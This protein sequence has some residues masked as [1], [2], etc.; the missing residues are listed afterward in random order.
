MAQSNFVFLK[1]TDDFLFTILH[2]A[3]K[4]YPDDANTTLVKLRIAG[5]YVA[6]HL[7]KLL[8]I[9]PQD[10]QYALL[11]EIA[12][13]TPIDE[14]ILRI[15]HKLRSLGNDAVHKY[16][17]DLNDAEMCLR[18]SFRLAVWYYRLMSNDKDFA[19]PLFKLP[20]DKAS[21]QK[22]EQEIAELKKLLLEANNN[23]AQKEHK[24]QAELDA[25]QAKVIQLEGLLAVL[26]SKEKETLAQNEA[27]ILAL[28]SQLKQKDVELAKLSES[29]R[30]SFH[31]QTIKQANQ[32]PLNLNEQETRYLIDEQ[33]RL[34]GWETDT[35]NLKYSNGTRPQIGRNMAIA[36]W[37][38]GVDE[39]GKKGF[40]DYV[41]FIGLTPVGV[42]EAKRYNQDVADKL[43]EAYRYSRTFDMLA[44]QNE[45]A[46]L[47]ANDEHNQDGILKH[48]S[49]MKTNQYN[50]SGFHIPFCFSANGRGH[51]AAVKTKSGIWYRDVRLD[52]NQPDS[53]NQ[54]F[55]PA[56]L[57][58]KL[59]QQ[60]GKLNSWFKTNPDMSDLGLRYFQE[61]A[62]RA[63]E[64]AVIEG[65][66]SALLA[67]A[68]GTGKTRTAIAIMYRMI[69]SQR[70]K[71]VL[72]LVDRR[73]LG[74]QALNS[75]E[76]TRIQSYTFNEI[77]NIKGLTDRFPEDSTKVHIATVQSLVKRV[78]QGDNFVGVGTYDAIIIDEAHR[79]YIL[80]KEQTEGELAFRDQRDYISAYRRVIDHF[81]A[82]K[83]ALT[84]TPA[85]HTSE[86]FGRPVYTYSY[87]TAVIDGYLNDYEP[88]IK[89][90][91][92]LNTQGVCI[93]EGEQVERL[94]V[95]GDV[96]LDTL[97]DEQNFEVDHFNRQIILPNFTKAI[98]GE[99]TKYLDPTSEQKT[100]I[101]CVNNEH[102][103]T[104]VAELHAAFKG[105]YPDL[106]HDAIMKIT[107]NSD[108][109]ANKV[110][111][112]IVK[113]E[114]EP[115]IP[116]IV[117]T[118]DLLTTG[119]DVPSICNLVFLR[120]VRS[121]I[122]YEQMKGR[123]TRLCP[124]VG[125]TSFRIFDAVDL[126]STLQPVDTM[127]SVVVRPNVSL[128]TLVKEIS[129]EETYQV[130]E[131]NDKSFAENSHEQL[132]SKLQRVIV[133]AEYQQVRSPEVEK[134][135]KSID[136]RLKNV[137]PCGFLELAKTL[138]NEG[139]KVSAQYFEKLPTLVEQVEDLKRTINSLRDRPI[140]SDM[141]DEVIGVETLFGDYNKAEDFL[142]AF[143]RLVNDNKNKLTALNAV[144]NRPRDLTR[145]GLVELQ[146]WFDAKHFD[147]SAL[148]VA[149]YKT[150]TQEIAAKLV[151]HIRRA[152]MKNPV[153]QPFDARVDHALAKIK[154][155]ND[156]NSVQIQ[157]LDRLAS[158]I[159]EKVVLDDDVYK[160]GNYARYGG[161]RKLQEALNDE[162]DDILHKFSEYI[163]DERA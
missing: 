98:C 17:N 161:K 25:Q 159:K 143:D 62:V 39:T 49:E 127:Q 158:S 109:D 41:L 156:W 86:I 37:P 64:Q 147:E 88:P 16:H 68:T 31:Q 140:F 122:L 83:L 66:R 1:G 81:D 54:W 78:L 60:I 134:A 107:G 121:R 79:G 100:L 5:E 43:N 96:E 131:A 92:K 67:M 146:E 155:E 8:N 71:R 28:E 63:V 90:N 139:P 101:F 163:W 153:L 21:S 132:I 116:N 128:S 148:Q 142:E 24:S 65:K 51:S 150:T 118:V 3:E 48:V 133:Q 99:L 152:S 36:E 22:A 112:L 57:Q 111:E 123:A 52:T 138:R 77:F 102:A 50:A 125:K 69:Q 72:F 114:K 35:E 144:I 55:T 70:F 18:L 135:V 115:R 105:Q 19:A 113:F 32:T 12:N 145:K 136:E 160:I 23:A 40:A 120:K 74:N 10:T 85:A 44:Y 53:L 33:L 95:T 84:A 149:W 104:V 151:G 38:T 30:K 29:E 119:I 2:T 13:R 154:S 34:S 97:E 42:V 93:A 15:F 7:G 59:A 89:I 94:N 45:L 27:R 117:V 129:E 126:Y 137:V 20:I 73:S 87:R 162:L 56:E 157:W 75:F 6:K 106:H 46:Q 11:Q 14:S 141:P 4:N 124:K 61:D 103:D 82:F 108:K 76:S 130:I 9:E 80:D 47:A 58:S 26:E 110:Q 91:T